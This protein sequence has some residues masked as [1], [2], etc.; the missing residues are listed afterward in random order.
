VLHSG[1]SHICLWTYKDFSANHQHLAR[2]LTETKTVRVEQTRP[3]LN[4]TK[5]STGNRKKGTVAGLLN[6]PHCL[7]FHIVL[8]LHVPCGTTVFL[9]W[10]C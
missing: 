2:V 6:S 10:L 7:R 1:P 3:K 4:N 9:L 5:P 8:L